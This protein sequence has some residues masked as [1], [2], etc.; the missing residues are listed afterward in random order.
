MSNPGSTSGDPRPKDSTTEDEQGFYEQYSP[1]HE[2]PKSSLASAIIHGLLAFAIGLIAT[3]SFEPVH[4]VPHVDVV[5]LPDDAPSVPDNKP[6]PPEDLLEPLPRHVEPPTKPKQLAY[7]D[8]R[9]VEIPKET[10]NE[11]GKQAIQSTAGEA[12]KA[13]E[14]AAAQAEKLAKRLGERRA[15]RQARWVIRIRDSASET[16]RQLEY[17]DA[18][19]MVRV[20][21]DTAKYFADLNS[22]PPSSRL[23]SIDAETRIWWTFGEG[24]TKREIVD[25]LDMNHSSVLRCFFPS[26]FED[27]LLMLETSYQNRREEDIRSTTFE[28]FRSGSEYDVRVVE[29]ELK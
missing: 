14:A 23:Q 8:V 7:E 10:I 15:A 21:E 13:Q 5:R 17:F 11:R 16:M 28:F 24:S 6:A 27:R 26:A 20:D 3:A 12:A 25:L 2:L 18:E 22:R 1:N 29:Q 19:L 9:Q 4:T